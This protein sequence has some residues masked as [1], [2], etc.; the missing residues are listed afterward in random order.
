M[1]TKP[2][3]QKYSKFGMQDFSSIYVTPRSALITQQQGTLHN[4]IIDERRKMTDKLPPWGVF[5]A[6]R[7]QP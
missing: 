3:R 5:I 4:E 7:W 2:K 1:K 6:L